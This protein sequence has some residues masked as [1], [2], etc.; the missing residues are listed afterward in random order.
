[1][2]KSRGRKLESGEKVIVVCKS[3]KNDFPWTTQMDEMI[4]GTYEVQLA[5]FSNVRLLNKLTGSNYMFPYESLE[6]IVDK[7]TTF[8]SNGFVYATETDM[9]IKRLRDIVLKQDYTKL[10]K[11]CDEQKKGIFTLDLNIDSFNKIKEDCPR[12]IGVLLSWGMLVR[13]SE[14]NFMEKSNV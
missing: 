14:K 7:L 3:T 4:G 11:L 5:H 10:I 1:M 6:L 13:T 12:V 2:T 9:S 8:N